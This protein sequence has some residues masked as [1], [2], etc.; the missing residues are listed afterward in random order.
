MKDCQRIVTIL[1]VTYTEAVYLLQYS[2]THKFFALCYLSTKK[3]D[4][5]LHE[6]KS[7]VSL[8]SA[9]ETTQYQ[10]DTSTSSWPKEVSSSVYGCTLLMNM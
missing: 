1:I 5:G 4:L 6:N 8:L 7:L 9:S 2:V 3:K 10:T